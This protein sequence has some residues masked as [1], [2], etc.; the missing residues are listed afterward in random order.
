MGDLRI[1]RFFLP[2]KCLHPSHLPSL[3]D[4]IPQIEILDKFELSSSISSGMV[5]RG[6]KWEGMAG[7]GTNSIGHHDSRGSP[8]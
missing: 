4:E 3:P 8:R 7:V 2:F 5:G 1:P 6:Q